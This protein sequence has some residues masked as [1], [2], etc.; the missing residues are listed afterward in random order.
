MYKE[1]VLEVIESIY[2]LSIDKKNSL[3]LLSTHSMRIVQPFLV[4][5]KKNA[6]LNGVRGYKMGSRDA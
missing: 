6:V 1:I 3:R 2:P 4:P 5:E